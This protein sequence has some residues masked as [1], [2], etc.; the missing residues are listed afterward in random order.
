MSPRLRLATNG[1]P[2]FAPFESSGAGESQSFQGSAFQGGIL[3]TRGTR[4]SQDINE[5]EIDEFW[6]QLDGDSDVFANDLFAHPAHVGE[7][8]GNVIL[9]AAISGLPV[10]V[11]ESCGYAH[12]IERAD[13]GRLVRLP[14]QQSTF[15]QML[16]EMLTSP[17]CAQWSRNGI[18]Y[19]RTEDLYGLA[20]VAAD[21]IEQTARNTG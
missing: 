10:L 19:G 3:A 6:N 15:N 4:D 7:V 9:E 16:A 12:H 8:A 2:R 17:Q 5:R 18:A 14:Y 21:L 1:L 20:E 13:A 11:T